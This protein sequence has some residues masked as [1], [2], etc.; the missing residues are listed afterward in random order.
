MIQAPPLIIKPLS[1]LPDGLPSCDPHKEAIPCYLVTVH[2]NDTNDL[3]ASPMVWDEQEAFLSSLN[4]LPDL[5]TDT[6]G[7]RLAAVLLEHDFPTFRIS[8]YFCASNDACQVGPVYLPG[9]E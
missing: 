1:W 3:L 7:L 6:P 2:S 8:E 5:A 4:E 9:S